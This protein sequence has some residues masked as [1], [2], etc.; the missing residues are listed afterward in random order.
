MLVHA[1]LGVE[2]P[3]ADA[4]LAARGQAEAEVVRVVVRDVALRVEAR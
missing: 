3:V 4:C 1:H 2:V